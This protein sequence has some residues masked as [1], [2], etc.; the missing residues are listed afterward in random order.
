MRLKIVRIT[1]FG[2]FCIIAVNLFYTQII[3]GQYYYGLSVDNRIR[4]IPS[5]GRRGSILDRYGDVLVGNRLSFNVAVIP[6]DIKESE[7]LF[8]YLSEV[9]KTEKKELLQRFYQKKITPFAPVVIAEDIDKKIAMELEENRFRFPGLYVQETFRRHYPYHGLGAHVLGYVGKI[10]RS[11]ME[12]LE[13]YGYTPK[14]IVGY[15]GVE[16]SYDAFLKGE[17]GG[18]QIEV[19]AR[20]RQRRLLS[21]KEPQRGQDIQ[22]TIDARIQRLAFDILDDKSG[23]IIVMDLDTGGILGMVS[24]PAFDPNVLVSSRYAKEAASIFIDEGAPLLN[25]AIKGLYPPGSVFKTIVSLAGLVTKKIEPSTT[26]FCKGSYKLGRRRFRCAH[27]HGTNDLIGA[28]ARSCNVYFYN[29]GLLLG[30]EIM[31]KYARILGLGRLTHIDLPFEE[32]GSIPSPLQRKMKSNRGW[33]DGDT[34]N[35]SIGQG[36]VLVTPI[37]AVRMM[38]NVA[39][40]G[41]EVQPHLIKAIGGREVIQFSTVKNIHIKKKIFETV[42]KGLRDVVQSERGT[43]KILNMD[44]FEISGK[45]GTAQTAPGKPSHAWFVGYSTQGKKR[46]AFC[47]FIEHGGSSYYA[48]R[49]TRNFL[50]KLREEEII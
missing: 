5:E 3:R 1:I 45:T 37:Q 43:A 26:Y 39:R 11:R 17:E 13:E 20:G 30:P 2:F 50:K 48:V 40:G 16:E 8:D 34:L 15:L 35:F 33:Y 14:S 22:L 42:Q 4:V 10:S 18:K 47:I 38:A 27:V 46:I 19:D 12:K 36:D 25:R 31:N 6:Q 41:K 21:V 44:G 23:T 7:F 28:I 49:M 32:K 29:V 24:A 9:L